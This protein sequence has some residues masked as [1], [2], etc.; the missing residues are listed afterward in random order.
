MKRATVKSE[1]SKMPLYAF[2]DMEEMESMEP[3]EEEEPFGAQRPPDEMDE[4]D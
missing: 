3:D 1:T 2:G 4:D